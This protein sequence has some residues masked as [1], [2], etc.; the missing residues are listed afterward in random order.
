MVEERGTMG[1]ALGMAMAADGFKLDNLRHRPSGGN[2]PLSPLGYVVWWEN[3]L[4]RRLLALERT[5]IAPN[6]II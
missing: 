4:Y 1:F 2:K 3:T 6:A 5:N